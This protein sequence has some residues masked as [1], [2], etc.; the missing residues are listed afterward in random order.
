MVSPQ[1]CVITRISCSSWVI[2]IT[3]TLS[4]VY[5]SQ[6]NNISGTFALG[7]R[8]SQYLQLYATCM[9]CLPDYKLQYEYSSMS[10]LMYDETRIPTEIYSVLSGTYIVSINKF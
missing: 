6:Y 8:F 3:Y 7:T 1:T 4:K 9:A 2:T 5:L 10:V